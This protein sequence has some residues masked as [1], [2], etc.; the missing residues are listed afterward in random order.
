MSGVAAR[1][2]LREKCLL[3]E[4]T[5]ERLPEPYVAKWFVRF[6]VA[7]TIDDTFRGSEREKERESWWVFRMNDSEKSTIDVTG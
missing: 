3:E 7:V 2:C 5:N 6:L 1:V 4:R